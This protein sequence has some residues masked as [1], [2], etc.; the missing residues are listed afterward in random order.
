MA[1]AIQSTAWSRELLI[2]LVSKTSTTFIFR[3]SALLALLVQTK[4]MQMESKS[5]SAAAGKTPTGVSRP[6]Q[7]PRIELISAGIS[8]LGNSIRSSIVVGQTQISVPLLAKVLSSFNSTLNSLDAIRKAV[9]AILTISII[10]SML[11]AISILPAI[12]FPQSRL[13]VY[14]NIFWPA[15]ASVFAF[16]AAIALSVTAVLAS[17][18]NDFSD[19]LGVQIKQ[20]GTVLLMSWLSVVFAGL[21]TVYWS[22]VWFV[23]T[24]KSSFVKRR[25]DEDEIGHW[26]GV[27]GEV[28]RDLKGCRKRPSMRADI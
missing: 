24:R 4:V 7:S 6:S 2:R 17:A 21:V 9:F 12:Y 10:G 23:E 8:N 1:S 28:W 16:T 22:S 26:K 27:G 5:M 19:T 14:F 20:E 25:R 18:I 3:K 13:L 11:S 15:L